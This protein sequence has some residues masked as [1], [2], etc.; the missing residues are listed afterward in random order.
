MSALE[1]LVLGAFALL[2]VFWWQPGIKAAVARSKQS[3]ADWPSVV[4][5]LIWVVMFVLF[6]IAMV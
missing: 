2:L 3:P 4:I 1:S 6:L 5:P